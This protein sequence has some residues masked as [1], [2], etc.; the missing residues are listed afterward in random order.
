MSA[1]PPPLAT[2]PHGVNTFAE[3]RYP[4]L[5]R[6][7]RISESARLLASG[8]RRH[9]PNA[10]TRKCQIPKPHEAHPYGRIHE[11]GGLSFWCEGRS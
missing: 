4:D 3:R 2:E 5:F 10:T 11:H 8:D 9:H 1:L 7:V 6:G